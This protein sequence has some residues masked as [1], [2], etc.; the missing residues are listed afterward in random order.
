MYDSEDDEGEVLPSFEG[1][2]QM[3]NKDKRKEQKRKAKTESTFATYEEFA[4]LL[5]G[6]S[7]DE[8]QKKHLNKKISGVK[9]T[10]E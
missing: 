6:D 5:D 4:H 3:S 8:L 1:Q 2:K 9:R 7:D 10:Y